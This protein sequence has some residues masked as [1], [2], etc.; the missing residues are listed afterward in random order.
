[1]R[2][3]PSTRIL[4][5]VLVDA[6]KLPSPAPAGRLNG[7]P[8]SGQVGFPRVLVRACGRDVADCLQEPGAP[9]TR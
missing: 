9:Q 7:S 3:F 2:L 5:D 6:G 1:M 4:V 8:L